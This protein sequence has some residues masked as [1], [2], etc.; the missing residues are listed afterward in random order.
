M[1]QPATS[2]PPQPNAEPRHLARCCVVQALYQWQL[3]GADV[4]ELIAQQQNLASFRS[5]DRRYFKQ[6]LQGVLSL[7]TELD[8]TIT[9]HLDRKLSELNPVELAI[10]RMATYELYYCPRVPTKVVI[11]EAL[12]ITKAFGAEQGYR[13]VNGVLD[14]V[15]VNC[16]ARA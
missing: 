9:P 14:A 6:V 11:N 8:S 2:Q 15:R 7:S 4:A 10:L 16:A 5:I 13:Y 1:S 12:E 3:T